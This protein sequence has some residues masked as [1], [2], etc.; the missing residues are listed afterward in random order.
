MTF[1]LTKCIRLM[2]LG[3]NI[4]AIRFSELP[5][6]AVF[7][8]SSCCSRGMK[9]YTRTG[10]KGST[11]LF[12]GERRPKSDRIFDCLGNADELN[13]CLG[14][15]MQ[16]LPPPPGDEP[17]TTRLS[18]IQ[19]TLLDIGSQIAT[20]RSS[21]QPKQLERVC[22][23]FG[24]QLT[25]ELEQWIDEMQLELPPLRNFI[26]PSGG[27]C[28]S[29]LHLSRAVCRRF[30]RSLQ[31][32]ISSGDLDNKVGIYVNR[33]SDFLFVFARFVAM[34]EGKSETIYKKL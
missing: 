32:L 12:T 13:S 6:K 23:S 21:A 17:Y 28:A 4:S 20:P 27:K 2:R 18:K 9:I 24:D 1:R 33:L 3:C 25:S 26:L 10:D 14:V 15:A 22:A 29:M 19:S 30:E 8:S 31:P 11:S 34:K 7:S 5:A 16:F